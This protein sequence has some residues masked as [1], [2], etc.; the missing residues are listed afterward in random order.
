MMKRLRILTTIL[1]VL[2]LFLTAPLPALKAKAETSE[3]LAYAGAYACVLNDGTY[4]YASPAETD[5]LFLLPKTYYVKIV[6]PGETFCKI[7]YLYDDSH[8]KKLTG[9]AKTSELTFVDY[10]PR[11]PYLYYV[12]DVS[13]YI[14]ADGLNTDGF[15]N[16][17]TVT[18]AYYGD[19]KIGSKS[20]CY[21]LRGDSFGYIPK[22]AAL[23]FE[24]NTEYAE[25][26]AAANPTQPDGSADAPAPSP[27]SPAQ[28][29]ILVALCLLVP[30]LAAL[31]LKQPKRPPYERE[32]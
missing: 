17:L 31:I 7:E 19:Y 23:S 25:Y 3:P 6:E 13:Y 26:L 10:A 16:E 1:S 22:P 15:L 20:Y 12:F 27:S 2:L 24:E 32:E 5:G 8:V 9:Y 28:I 21:V 30:V 4:F 11:R 18:C 29:A 14:D